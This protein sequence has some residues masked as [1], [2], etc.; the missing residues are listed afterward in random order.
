[1]LHQRKKGYIK[2]PVAYAIEDF[3]G[4]V[5]FDDESSFNKLHVTRSVAKE[6]INQLFGVC[7][8]N[9]PSPQYRFSKQNMHMHIPFC[10]CPLKL[11]SAIFARPWSRNFLSYTKQFCMGNCNLAECVFH[12]IELFNEDIKD[13]IVQNCL[14]VAEKEAKDQAV[15]AMK[16]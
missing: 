4:D 15:R 9:L 10:S 3:F 14:S 12:R 6:V 1:M 16:K 2:P 8:Q 7:V 13:F 5:Y 11:S